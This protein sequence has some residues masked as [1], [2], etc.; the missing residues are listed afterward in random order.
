LSRKFSAD[1]TLNPN[2]K[3]SNMFIPHGFENSNPFTEFWEYF[4]ET[5]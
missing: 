3:Y 5:P 1:R 4:P 2:L